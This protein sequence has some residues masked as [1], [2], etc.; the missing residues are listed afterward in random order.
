MEKL[1]ENILSWCK[2]LEPAAT[3]QATNLSKHP[4]LVGNVCL[5]PDAH[6]GYGMPIGG[7][8]AL[9][10]ALSP[11]MVGVDIGCGMLAVQTSLTAIEHDKVKAIVDKIYERIPLGLSTTKKPKKTLSSWICPVGIRR[12]YVKG[13]FSLPKSR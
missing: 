11:N 9:D 6:C 13:S 8:V 2:N 10:N 3:Q 4:C 1:A 12:K 7:V 5:M